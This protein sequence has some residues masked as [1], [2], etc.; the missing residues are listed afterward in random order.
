[1]SPQSR[2]DFFRTTLGASL[3]SAPSTVPGTS[4]PTLP[5][6]SDN[7]PMASLIQLT[8][9]PR[10]AAIHNG[11]RSA[12]IIIFPGVRYE[13]RVEAPVVKPKRKRKPRATS[14]KPIVVAR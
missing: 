13:R 11:S 1:M 7:A 5:A 10:K 12:D 9:A 2:R 3:A 4:L 14:T 6:S 8:F